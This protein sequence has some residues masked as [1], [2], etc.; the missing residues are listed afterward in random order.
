MGGRSISLNFFVPLSKRPASDEELFKMLGC[1]F[2]KNKFGPLGITWH[3][4]EI[5]SDHVCAR[6]SF[7]YIELRNPLAEMFGTK[8][9]LHLDPLLPFANAI[10]EGAVRV[11]A[12]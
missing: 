3:G 5:L 1:D 8:I 4:I 11:G 10:R 9:P 12:E 2:V 6:I 7:L